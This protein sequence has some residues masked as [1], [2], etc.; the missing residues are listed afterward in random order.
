MTDYEPNEAR[1][2]RSEGWFRTCRGTGLRISPFALGMW[3]NFGAPGTGSL[4]LDNEHDFHE[5]CRRMLFTAFDNGIIHFDLANVYGPPPGA[6]EDRV[7]RILREDF[8]SHR[9]EV[10]IATKGG[11]SVHSGPNQKARNRKNLLPGLDESLSR[12]GTD[13]VDIFY[14]HGPDPETPLEETLA[15]LDQIVRSGK[16]LYSGICSY[17]PDLMSEAM[18][19][20]ERNGF[21]KPRFHQHAYHMMNRRAEELLPVCAREGVAVITFGSLAAGRLT[22]KY[23]D[24]VPADS[25]AGS[26]SRFLTPE[27]FTPEFRDGLR[28]LHEIARERGQTLTQMAISWCLRDDHLSTAIL[29]ASRPE[30]IAENLKAFDNRGFSNEE[31]RRIDGVLAH[32]PGW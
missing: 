8:G 22:D 28:G 21:V 30:Q 5:N 31:L 6:A 26:S 3:H 13:Y 4:G 24:G 15:A 27:E 32:L 14:V 19:V 20:C 7:G 25:R 12:L 2:E 23:L 29:G 18:R 17:K 16:A 1:Y 11:N 10:I 9:E